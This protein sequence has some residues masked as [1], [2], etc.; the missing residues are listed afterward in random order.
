MGVASDGPVVAMWASSRGRRGSA[1]P[2]PML[3]RVFADMEEVRV[4]AITVSVT[5]P[6]PF[7]VRSGWHCC[8]D[9]SP[10]SRARASERR[11]SFPEG[12]VRVWPWCPRSLGQEPMTTMSRGCR[13]PRS[14]AGMG[15]GT[16]RQ[17]WS[18]SAL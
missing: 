15:A 9:A 16:K 11:P 7:G 4:A 10:P 2:K 1:E 3:V 5:I 14:G 6:A 8:R 13:H 17:S 12:P 18:A